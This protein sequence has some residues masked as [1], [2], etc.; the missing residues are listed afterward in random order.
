MSKRLFFV[1]FAGFAFFIILWLIQP[2]WMVI[3]GLF[4][5]VL[6]WTYR[7]YRL[8]DQKQKSL[9]L[10]SQL[11]YDRLTKEHQLKNQQLET[12]MKHIPSPMALIDLQG[13]F[14]LFNDNFRRLT[15]GNHPSTYTNTTI[16]LPIRNFIRESYLNEKSTYQ[17][18]R[19][20]S[21]DYQAIS[22]PI[23]QVNRYAGML[24]VL[25]DITPALEKERMQKRFIADAS[26]ELKTPISA[27]KGMVEILNRP[28]FD[29]QET[30]REF[31]TQISVEINRLQGIVEDMLTMSKIH[32]NKLILD[33]QPVDITAIVNQAASTIRPV[34]LAKQITYIG[35]SKAVRT[36]FADGKQLIQAFDN[37]L[38]NAAQYT[39]NGKITVNIEENEREYIISFKDTG[40]GI[41]EQ[42]LP[43]I[44]ERFYRSAQDRAR[45]KGGSGLGLAIVKSIITAHQGRVEVY[46]KINEGTTFNVI[47]PKIN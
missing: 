12:L 8:F 21:T 41:E 40:I 16:P 31:L 37:L 4:L 33:L 7:I 47:L 39:F 46:S 30:S 38:H 25:Q 43:Y 13:D 14:V 9:Q 1:W 23:F 20:L 11:Q 5:F 15:Q 42:D 28:G 3:A 29:D 17:I 19:Y 35:P 2:S 34:L 44:F 32:A 36:V 10:S 27:I 26:H 22:I 45:T 18:L 6:I 24:I